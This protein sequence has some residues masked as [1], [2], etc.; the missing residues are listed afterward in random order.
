MKEEIWKP[1]SREDLR[2]TY[3]ISNLGRVKRQNG[4]LLDSGYRNMGYAAFVT[5]NKKGKNAMIYIHKVVAELFVPNPNSYTK[6]KFLDDTKEPRADNLQWLSKEEYKV[7]MQKRRTPYEAHPGH[8]PNC[9]LT[10][11]NVAVI[12]KMLKDGK[13]RKSII[14]KKFNVNVSAIY[15]IQSGKRWQDVKALGTKKSD[16]KSLEEWLKE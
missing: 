1:F 16:K 4:E 10:E 9:K 8:R 5:K 14:A 15:A 11:S 13:T 3:Y 7:E 12:K 2:N 6:L